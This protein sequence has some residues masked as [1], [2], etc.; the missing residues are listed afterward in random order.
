MSASKSKLLSLAE[1]PTGILFHH[2]K[3]TFHFI[4]FYCFYICVL[5]RLYCTYFFLIFLVLCYVLL[6]YAHSVL[7][8]F[9]CLVSFLF[10][11]SFV[12]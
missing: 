8:S 10:T 2:D 11:C 9:G 3:G 1:F 4:L 5:L 6:S 12:C 7:L